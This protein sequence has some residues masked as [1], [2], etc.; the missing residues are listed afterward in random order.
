MD[1]SLIDWRVIM[2]S[3]NWSALIEGSALNHWPAITMP[4]DYIIVP[5]V[6]VAKM[7]I[8]SYHGSQ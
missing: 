3:C 2:A 6:C 1:K 4:G 5:E 8:V 7:Y